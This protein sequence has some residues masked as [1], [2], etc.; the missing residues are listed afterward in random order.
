VNNWP[1]KENLKNVGNN[2]NLAE[3]MADVSWTGSRAVPCFTDI[4]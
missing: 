2:A 1:L 4:M 3:D